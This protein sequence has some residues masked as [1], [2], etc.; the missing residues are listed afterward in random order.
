MIRSV[1]MPTVVFLWLSWLSAQ[2]QSARSPEEIAQ[3]EAKAEAGDAGAQLRLG[4]AYDK[5]NGVPQS[6][7][8]AVKWYKAAAEQGNAEAQDDLGL[9][10]RSGRGVEKDKVEAVK[11]HKKAARQKNPAA[12]FN[13]GTAYYNGD[14]VSID[15]VSAYAWFLLAQDFGSQPA[16]EAVKIMKEEKANF[17]TAAFEKIGD[18]FSKG[19]SLPQSYSDAVRWYRKA[20]ESGSSSAPIELA[21]LLLQGP[22]AESNYPEVHR[23]CE[24]AATSRVSGLGGMYCLGLLYQ[25][26]WGVSPDLKMSAKWFNKAAEMGSAPALLRLGQMYWNGEGVKKDRIA[27]Y[28]FVYLAA[29]SDMREAK[30][31]KE[32]LEKEMTPKEMEKGRTQAIAWANQHPPTT[33]V[34]RRP[35]Q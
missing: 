8:Q 29:S 7:S 6:D 28:K 34:L 12:M 22:N 14:G 17:E 16:V 11:W 4:R 9:M 33:L 25:K 27:A 20:V 3:L 13:L 26:G 18:M 15:D 19:D 23:L 35:T 1:G 24:D 30:Q 10:Y 32:N 21:S 5:G 2:P 31:E